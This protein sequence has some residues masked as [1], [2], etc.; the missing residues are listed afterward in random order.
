MNRFFVY[1]L[2]FFSFTPAFTFAQLSENGIKA[3]YYNGTE[4]NELV[5]T[6]YENQIGLRLLQQSPAPG[7]NTRDY[8]IRWTGKLFAPVSGVYRLAFTADDGVRLWLGGKLLI[9]EWELQ[10]ERTFFTPKI[11]LHEGRYYDLK[12]EYYNG[13]MHG[14]AELSWERPDE[15]EVHANMHLIPHKYLFYK[16]VR[17]PAPK[18]VLTVVPKP[19]PA[20]T[21]KTSAITT[22]PAK[23]KPETKTPGSRDSGQVVV[24]TNSTPQ[25]EAPPKDSAKTKVQ[26][27]PR[28][29]SET[30]PEVGQKIVLSHLFFEQSTATLLPASYP[31]LERLAK[32]LMVHKSLNIRIEGHTDNSGNP[33]LNLQLSQERA[34]ILAKYL[35]RH[36]VSKRRIR[37]KGFGGA[38]PIADNRIPGERAKNRRVEF[39]LEDTKD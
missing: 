23:T 6:R 38:V 33:K 32:L 29:F 11:T 21:G 34:A 8:S 17:K 24:T 22:R 13:V 10:E 16:V 15:T 26:N 7:V 2:I 5:L 18:P 28:D 37:T 35:I 25:P 3:E 27:I 19:S 9:D 12:I 30:T 4:F 14:V 31:E 20:G 36:G 39:I 1:L